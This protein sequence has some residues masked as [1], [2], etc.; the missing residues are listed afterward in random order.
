VAAIA[1]LPAQAAPSS[2]ETFEMKTTALA[3]A[4]ICAFPAI[5]GVLPPK[6]QRSAI[7]ILNAA[8]AADMI[9]DDDTR[10]VLQCLACQPRIHDK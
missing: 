7:S 3:E 10:K 9:E 6:S 1:S 5:L 2:P 8:L 4:M